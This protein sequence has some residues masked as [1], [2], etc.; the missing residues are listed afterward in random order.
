MPVTGVIAYACDRSLEAVATQ[1]KELDTECADIRL[2]PDF[3]A[4]IGQ[5]IIAP[6]TPLRGEFNSF[7]LPDDRSALVDLRKTGRHTLFRLYIQVLRELNLIQL[8]PLDLAFYDQMPRLIG[9]YESAAE[10]GS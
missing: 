1:I 10:A 2:R 7:Q 6:R 4:I 9:P 5:G 8:R 3:I